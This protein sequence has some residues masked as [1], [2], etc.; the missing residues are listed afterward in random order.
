MKKLIA[1]LVC[2][3]SFSAQ[4][5]VISVELSESNPIVGETV[6]VN[7]LGSGF[8][9][10]DALNVDLEFDT[11]LFAVDNLDIFGDID[12]TTVGSDLAVDGWAANGGFLALSAQ[13]FG[14]AL[15]FLDFDVF[16]GGDFTI[17]SFSL[18]AIASGVSD[19]ALIN[20]LADDFLF[21][22]VD[23][24]AS[25]VAVSAEVS[26]PATISLFAIAGLA[27]FGFRRKA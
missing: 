22:P 17:A 19:F 12:A 25:D 21:G 13:T 11:S 8:D 20:I 6:Q 24:V 9:A 10:F 4:A 27:L 2:F 14:V 5:G 3:I 15:S 23:A 7:I 26:A 18:T 1:A 16:A